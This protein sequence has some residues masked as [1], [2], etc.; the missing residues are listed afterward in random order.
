MSQER[1]SSIT[2]ST[3]KIDSGIMLARVVGYLDPTFM[4]GIEVTLLRD[5]GNEVGDMHQT[6]S[7]K[8]A[9]PFYGVTG[10]EYMG[11]NKDNFSDTQKS[12]GMWFPTPEIGTTVLVA[13]IN[14]N[15]A[16]GYFIG[17]VPGKFMNHM[18]P[19]IGASTQVELSDA[20]KKLF[21]TEQP[22]PVAEVNRKAN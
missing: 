20:A 19:A 13:F 16:E 3:G 21:D 11:V 1:R 10:Y 2:N 5:Q 8:Y 9:T 6:Y 7:V 12:Y 17:C 22:L 15:P 4:A 14:G 18:I